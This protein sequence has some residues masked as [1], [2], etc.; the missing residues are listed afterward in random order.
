MDETILQL[1]AE[2]GFE[3]II[4]AFAIIVLTGFIKVPIKVLAKKIPDFTKL[5]RYI[6]FLP[7][8]FGFF[9]TLLYEVLLHG[10][11]EFNRSFITLWVSS[12]SLSLT[13][14]AFWEKLFPSK[15]K[16]LKDYEIEANRK[17]L[18]EI[19]EL[20]TKSNEEKNEDDEEKS[21]DVVNDE[22]DVNPK[23][24]I[25]LRGNNNE[26]IEIKKE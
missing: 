6:V 20:T 15:E 7:V 26:K 5:T 18:D 10:T 12:S 19:K 9:L 23:M 1:I 4:I 24:K 14:Y 17:L 21:T 8:I 2:Y 11:V 25:I 16:I 13:L 22:T 3:A